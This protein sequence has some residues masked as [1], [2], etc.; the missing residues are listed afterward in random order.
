M[1]PGDFNDGDKDNL[2]GLLGVEV[3]SVE[4]GR[5]EAKLE[6]QQHHLAI[7]SYLH[8]GTILTLADSAAGYGCQADL[9]EGAIGFTTMEMKS[10][11]LSTATEGTICCVAERLHAGRNTQVWEATVTSEVTGKMLAKFMCSQMIL[12]PRR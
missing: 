12:Y 2:P 11:H 8:A 6:L 4:K 9:P 5:I 3:T 1:T 10:N 7:N